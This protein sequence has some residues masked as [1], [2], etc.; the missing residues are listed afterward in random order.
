MLVVSDGWLAV[1][2]SLL[3]SSHVLTD[4]LSLLHFIPTN[5][6]TIAHGI[7]AFSIGAAHEYLPYDFD[8]YDDEYV[9]SDNDGMCPLLPSYK[10]TESRK[11]RPYWN[12]SDP[13]QII[14]D[15]GTLTKISTAVP[16]I[17]KSKPL[18]D[19]A[20]SHC[21]DYVLMMKGDF[22]S[23]DFYQQLK[24]RINS[25]KAGETIE[26]IVAEVVEEV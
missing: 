20:T 25:W 3:R 6:T 8:L 13:T 26:D 10:G 24:H 15:F 21:G 7:L 2:Y 4:Y 17:P 19:A 22:Y 14:V 1:F 11:S 23:A 18:S 5:N 9:Y 16:K 12:P